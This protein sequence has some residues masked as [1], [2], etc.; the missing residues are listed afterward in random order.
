MHRGA[1]SLVGDEAAK[2]SDAPDGLSTMKV[3]GGLYIQS[4]AYSLFFS[5]LKSP[6]PG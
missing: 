4:I 1:W 2:E 3:S 6:V 5:I